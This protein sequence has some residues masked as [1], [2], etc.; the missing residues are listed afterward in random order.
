MW[1]HDCE[2]PAHNAADSVRFENRLQ[3]KT[4]RKRS[5]DKIIRCP[6]CRQRRKA[7]LERERARQLRRQGGLFRKPPDR[8]HANARQREAYKSAPAER[9]EAAALRYRNDDQAKEMAK[10]SVRILQ[11]ARAGQEYAPPGA[12][13]QRT[14]AELRTAHAA[15]KAERREKQQ[16]ARVKWE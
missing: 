12:K 7:K 11:R 1:H 4:L 16:S 2:D 8:E 14:L 3:A 6:N 9:K 10:L 5:S 13:D 15:I